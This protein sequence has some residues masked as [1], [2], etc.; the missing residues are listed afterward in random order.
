MGN[1][2]AYII[3]TSPQ[4]MPPKH[5]LPMH[6]NS[7]GGG[8]QYKSIPECPRALSEGL[9]GYSNQFL[10]PPAVGSRCKRQPLYRR[11]QEARMQNEKEERLFSHMFVVP[12]TVL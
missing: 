3:T 9:G 8:R 12:F 11:A 1:F 5:V 10:P 6:T 7:S 4:I 2:C